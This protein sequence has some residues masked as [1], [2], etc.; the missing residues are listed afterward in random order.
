[1][2]NG[3]AA[4]EF[5]CPIWQQ[6]DFSVAAGLFSQLAGVLAGF[7]FVGITLKLNSQTGQNGDSSEVDNERFLTGLGCAFVGLIAAAALYATI[8]ASKGCAIVTGTGASL[9]VLAGVAFGL[10]V[11]TLLFAT[12]QLASKG[13]LGAH[14][15]GLVAVAVPPITML[16]VASSLGDLALSQAD[17][18]SSRGDSADDSRLPREAITPQWNNEEGFYNFS[19]WATLW[20]T[21]TVFL[22]CLILWLY[23]RKIRR[24]EGGAVTSFAVRID[25]LV[26]RCLT[27]VP[28]AS[29][30][31][32]VY[33]VGRSVT[34]STLE[35][36]AHMPAWEATTAVLGAA[37]ILC[38]NSVS[39]S[40][41]RGSEAP[42]S[43]AP[44]N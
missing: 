11:Y 32:V 9:E 5:D 28:Y 4:P 25:S 44:L 15:R 8:S 35:P 24:A 33:A 37:M 12:V 6:F 22:I 34:F 36:A 18:P 14:L 42:I 19:R 30:V 2:T 20:L 26:S 38:L 39:L 10:S 21:I 16:L 13:P 1:M 31:M 17:P 43:R 23:G 7:A 41:V 27:G 3:G 29:V 40:L